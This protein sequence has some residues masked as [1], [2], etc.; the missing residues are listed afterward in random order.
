[1][2]I[3]SSW[4]F[5]KYILSEIPD[6]TT[7]TKRKLPTA[8]KIYDR[9]GKLLY[10]FYKDQNRTP[11]E[12]SKMSKAVIDATIAI[13]DKE[14]FK[15][16]GFSIRG[17]TRAFW[18]N[19]KNGTLYGGSTITQ[20]LVKNAFLGSEK[21]YIRKLKEITLAILVEKQFPKH[22]ILEM[23]L[24]EVP[25]GGV[26]YGI[27]AA[28]Q[29]YFG[30]SAS[31]LSI[32]EAALLAGL[33]RSPTTYSPF[34]ENTNIAIARRNEVLQQ[35]HSAGFIS[36]EELL[37]AKEEQVVFAKNQIHIKAP[38]FVFYIRD[39]LEKEYGRDAINYNG[40]TVITSLDLEIQ[41]KVEKIVKEEVE[42]L[43]NM[44]VKNGAAIVINPKT[45][46]IL[47]MVG[48]KDYFDTANNGNVNM[49]TT[50]RQPGS[51]IKVVNYANALSNGY[52]LATR[53]DDTPVSYKIAGQPTYTPKNY[54]GGFKGAM[55]L[56]S[57]LAQSRNIPAVKTLNHF[58]V[59]SMIAM[60]KKMGITTWEEKTRFGLSLT[61]GG[62]ETTLLD[63]SYV[64]A[65]LANYGKRPK[66]NPILSITNAQGKMIKKT[67]ARKLTRSQKE[68][69]NC[70][71]CLRQNRPKS[72][73]FQKTHAKVSKSLIQESH[74]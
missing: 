1:M 7:L 54:E 27:E 30:K 4:L 64:Y 6:P 71:T 23:Y 33:P 60:G 15:H 21:T 19:I 61:L 29:I 55:T 57:A 73:I 47:A 39:I 51:T 53:I 42:K 32:S 8:T 52:T 22:K 13:E 10:T 67:I 36:E 44:N 14:F 20:Q 9:N 3:V 74:F 5:T 38:H 50:P 12:I 65:T 63:M 62:G 26:A 16:P 46:E 59:D 2:F 35:M 31:E 41:E 48:S 28:A 66:I 43:K 37:K 70:Q 24:N 69:L 45:G 17:I 56:R 58:G 25:Y 68:F 49:T 11:I 18:Q 34:G 72:I 40:L